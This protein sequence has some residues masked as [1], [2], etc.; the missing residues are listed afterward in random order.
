MSL[1][2]HLD[3]LPVFLE[4]VRTGSIRGASRV[5]GR[6]QPTISRTIRILEDAVG[7]R[8]FVREPS[9]IK[10]T[11]R[12][13]ALFELADQLRSSIAGFRAR[14]TAERK[15]QQQI[16]FGAFE[17]I[18]VYLFPGF[19]RYAA[20][21]QDELEISLV[22]ASSAELMTALRRSRV[23]IILTVNPRPHRDV[24]SKVLFADEYRVYRH[25]SS[26][27]TPSTPV[28]A[29]LSAADARGRTI[30]SYLA[31]SHLARRRRFVCESFELANALTIAGLGLGVLPTRVAQRALRRGELVED[32]GASTPWRFGS[33]PI[34]VSVL[35]HRAG[36]SGILWIH[37]ALEQYEARTL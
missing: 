13:Q 17:S 30:E 7:A 18:A 19:L 10:L 26:V 4:T 11:P 33:H 12:G 16:T 28:M 15:I 20:D 6:S 1:E 22:T 35:A 9:G 37:R 36:D 3:K 31:R 32:D 27:V 34:A 25:P 2:D 21:V 24:R 5:L 29:F 14:S 23:D 8:L